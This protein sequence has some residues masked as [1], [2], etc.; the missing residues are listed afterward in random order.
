M[1]LQS[2][3]ITLPNELLFITT[4]NLIDDWEKQKRY[5]D[6]DGGK[7]GNPLLTLALTCKRL[8]RIASFILYRDITLMDGRSLE[9][10]ARCLRKSGGTRLGTFTE[11]LAIGVLPPRRWVEADPFLLME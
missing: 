9:R 7:T 8:E 6:V 11:S 3:L 2:K 4:Q 5:R 10:L 1:P